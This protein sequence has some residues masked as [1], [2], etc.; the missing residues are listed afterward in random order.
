MVNSELLDLYVE[1]FGEEPVLTGISYNDK[2]SLADKLIRA[3]ETEEPL[4]EREVPEGS[5]V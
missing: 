4:I 1:V 5:V 2:E 3:I